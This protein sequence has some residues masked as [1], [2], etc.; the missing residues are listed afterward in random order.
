MS[1]PAVNVVAPTDTGPPRFRVDVLAIKSKSVVTIFLSVPLDPATVE[2]I[3]LMTL[4]VLL[5]PSKVPLVMV[6]PRPVANVKSSASCHVP[7]TPLKITGASMVLVFEVMMFV[8]D[9]AAKVIEP[10]DEPNVI[11]DESVKLP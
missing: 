9:V 6:K 2:P 4:I 1:V 8:P 10:E 5:L 3:P 11:P 7:P